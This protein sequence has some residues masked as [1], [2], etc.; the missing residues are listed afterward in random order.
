MTHDPNPHGDA[1]LYV[2][3]GQCRAW[4]EAVTRGVARS[5]PSDFVV[6]EEL[7]FSPDGSGAHTLVHLRK[8]SA[9][10]DWATRCLAR[11]AGVHVRDVGFCGLK[12]RNAVT[13]QWFSVPGA[14]PIDP[15]A[16]AD[17]GLEVLQQ[18]PHGRK[19]RRGSHRG[20]RFRIV[21]DSIDGT[22]AAIEQ[23]LT[24][25][26]AAG[27]PNYFGPQRFGRQ[28]KNLTLAK[29]LSGG[30]RLDRR[31]RG[32]A[33][34]AARAALFNNLL[35]RRVEGGN[36]NSLVP[37]DVAVLD[38]TAS[39]FHVDQPDEDMVN[40]V[41]AMDLHPSG[42]LWGRGDVATSGVPRELELELGVT[43]ELQELCSCVE[44][45]GM[46]QERRALR[47]PVRELNWTLSGD[48]LRMSFYLP[49]G[50]FATAVLAE[51]LAA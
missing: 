5:R 25:I 18:V 17:M 20:N 13:S 31:R 21:L 34:S 51:I 45:A 30:A 26:S 43:G 23:R 38:G 1:S 2:T 39:W 29:A 27:V 46:K 48:Q 32:F 14:P 24:M 40:R 35:S 10:T 22:P 4:G 37:G 36:W 33:L 11:A 19:L 9:N 12:D 28:G 44:Q 16:L 42:P 15:N 47:L 41:L 7:G 3:S 8:T 6:E 50:A 49:R